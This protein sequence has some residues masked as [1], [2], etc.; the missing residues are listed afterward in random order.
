M[1][2]AV[3]PDGRA[4]G[5]FQFYGANR[6]GCW[7]GRIIQMQNL[8][9]NHLLD[10]AEA[11]GLVRCGD[12]NGVEPLYKDIPDTLSQLI[13]AA[14]VPKPDRIHVSNGTLLLDGTLIGTVLSAIFDTNMKDGSIRKIS[15][16]C[17]AHAELEHILL[18]RDERKKKQS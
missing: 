2:K 13:R 4:R 15:Q 17:F 16:D 11:R 6:T 18:C 10:L 3:R 14:F 5:M 1:E 7:A 12:F 8:P 9:Q